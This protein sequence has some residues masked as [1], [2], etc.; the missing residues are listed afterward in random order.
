MYV[1]TTVTL[2]SMKPSFA[3]Y[4]MFRLLVSL[5]LSLSPS[6]FTYRIIYISFLYDTS[7]LKLCLVC[8]K[9]G[10]IS[11]NSF[12]ITIIF[13]KL[14]I[15]SEKIDIIVFL[16]LR[17]DNPFYSIIHIL[18]Y[19]IKIIIGNDLVSRFINFK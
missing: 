2:K 10:N 13:Y 5:S 15:M 17:N 6:F 1:A 7:Y 16:Y 8:L 14:I 9:Y 12:I 19:T 3:I 11:T 4:L 18:S